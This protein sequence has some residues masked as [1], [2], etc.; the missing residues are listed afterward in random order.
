MTNI[1]MPRTTAPHRLLL[2]LS[3]PTAVLAAS[4]A[5]AVA[6]IPWLPAPLRALLLLAFVLIGPGCALL[7]WRPPLPASVTIVLAP[8]LGVSVLALVST[9]AAL[10]SWWHPTAQLLLLVVA[11]VVAVL[12]RLRRP[13]SERTP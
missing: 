8:T 9:A 11:C 10:F 13:A 6:A 3:L 1:M 7:A 12:L 4:A 5:G 2:P